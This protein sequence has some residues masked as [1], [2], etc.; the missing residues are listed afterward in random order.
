MSDEGRPLPQRER[1]ATEAGARPAATSAGPRELTDDLRQRMQA[2]VDAERAQARERVTELL[3]HPPQRRAAGV[4][5]IPPTADAPDAAGQS[6]PARKPHAKRNRPA[7]SDAPDKPGRRGRFDRR[8]RAD[9]PARPG[10]PATSGPNVIMPGVN[11]TPPVNSAPAEPVSSNAREANVQDAS[12]LQLR[13]QNSPLSGDAHPSGPT[14]PVSPG[15][16]SGPASALGQALTAGAAGATAASPA[17]EATPAPAADPTSPAGSTPATDPSA[18]I[19]VPAPGLGP[20]HPSGPVGSPS[21]FTPPPAASTLAT[22]PPA[23]PAF[24]GSPAA[25][26]RPGSPAAAPAS[27]PVPGQP[28]QRRRRG[29]AGLIAGAVSVVAAAAVAAFLLM[30]AGPA[31]QP[32]GPSS[33]TAAPAAQAAAVKWVVNQVNPKTTVACDQATCAAL[34]AQG[35]SPANLRK[36]TSTSALP[37]SGIVVVTPIA[38]RL[39]GSSLATAW[40]PAALATFG[41]G[42]SAVSVRIVAP[43][44]PQGAAKWEQQARQDQADRKISEAALL[45]ARTITVSGPAQQDLQAGRIDG[46]LMEAVAD[47]ASTEPI[48]IVEFGNVGMGASAEV[49]LRYADL[50]VS[51][52]AATNPAATMG[53]Q[54]YIQALRTGMNGGPGPRPDRTE[55]L[56]LPGGQKVLRIEFLAPSPFGVLTN[57]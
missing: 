7:H 35:Y 38:S 10:L 43:A 4:P 42:S 32:S 55:L 30:S 36:I 47:A 45:Q 33:G 17:L 11:G 27:A 53:T 50:A 18:P 44:G 6:G 51:N 13:A 16:G 49:P 46:R 1:G 2:A 29:R 8:G 23:A 5:L 14:G 56:T 12:A 3:R 19:S 54:A 15:S 52:P 48:D 21:S 24:H 37:D 39:F 57:P 25:R 41:R 40:A 26:V 34:V 20:G 9:R 28:R 31:P 22:P